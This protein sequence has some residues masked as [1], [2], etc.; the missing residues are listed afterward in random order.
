[1]KAASSTPTGWSLPRPIISADIAS[2]WSICVA[3]TP[4]PG[5]RPG[6]G[7]VGARLG[8]A[9]AA[10]RGAAGAGRGGPADGGRPPDRRRQEG[11]RR[12]GGGADGPP[13]RG[14]DAVPHLLRGVK[15]STRLPPCISNL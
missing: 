12:R 11:A 6:A 2:R 15:V 10:G 5:A 3:T 7:G 13:P 14:R 1:M 4:P 8:A 9:T